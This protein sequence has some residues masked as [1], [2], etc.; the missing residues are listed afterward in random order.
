[1]NPL[2]GWWK[3]PRQLFLIAHLLRAP[4]FLSTQG[5]LL[6]C[7]LTFTPQDVLIISS[8]NTI[9]VYSTEQKI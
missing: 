3:P 6:L 8:K 2:F 7:L 4:S 9:S 1:M 5:L